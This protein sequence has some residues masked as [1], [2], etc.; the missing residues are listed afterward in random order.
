MWSTSTVDHRTV[1]VVRVGLGEGE[2]ACCLVGRVCPADIA[3]QGGGKE[4][5]GVGIVLE[6]VSQQGEG[7]EKSQR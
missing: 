6:G 4:G 5:G 2:S 7:S 1:V 3:C